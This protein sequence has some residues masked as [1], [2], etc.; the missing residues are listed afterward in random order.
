MCRYSSAQETFPSKP[1]YGHAPSFTSFVK[2]TSSYESNKDAI[3]VSED[4]Y[5][6]VEELMS[7]SDDHDSSMIV[8]P[9]S[10]PSPLPTCHS[11]SPS[12][13]LS[14][15][16]VHPAGAGGEGREGKERRRLGVGDEELTL[17]NGSSPTLKVKFSKEDISDSSPSKFKLEINEKDRDIQDLSAIKKPTSTSSIIPQSKT[18]AEAIF[19]REHEKHF[20]AVMTQIIK[21][22]GLSLSWLDIIQPL[23]VSATQTVRTDVF[24]DDVMDI[25]EYVRVKKIPCGLRSDSSLNYGAVCTKNVT[26][27]KMNTEIL[28]PS[29]LLLKCAF[30]FQ[31]RENQLSSFD[32]LHLQENKYL[33]NL[34]DKVKAFKPDIILVQKS[35]SRLALEDLYD[36]GI[37]VVVNVK[38]SVMARVSR[39]T[40]G[41]ILTSLDQLF[42]NVHLGTCGKFYVRNFTLDSGVKKT[43]MYFDHCEEKLG[44]VITLQG[45]SSRELKK[46]K[47]VTQFGLHISYNSMLES[48]FLLDEFARLNSSNEERVIIDSLG[49]Y[50]STPLTPEFSLYPSIAHPLDSLPPS[51]V[52]QRLMELGLCNDE[53]VKPPHLEVWGPDEISII[54]Q[55]G[56]EEG[57]DS[58]PVFNED[59]EEDKDVIILQETAKLMS[60]SE[61]KTCLTR[62]S[63]DVS[64]KKNENDNLTKSLTHVDSH[65]FVPQV[66][67]HTSVPQ[68]DSHT[69]V[70]RVD[71]H[72]SVPQV[73]D[74]H[75]STPQVDPHAS[76]PQVDSH[77]FIPQVDSKSEQVD[78]QT[79]FVQ[80]DSQI[81]VESPD[82]NPDLLKLQAVDRDVLIN[83]SAKEFEMV[84]KKQLLS[85]SPNVK[86]PVP[87]LQ[88]AQ[89]NEADI[90]QY[91][92][93]VIY[94]SFQFKPNVPSS[95]LLWKPQERDE[96]GDALEKG[97]TKT[98]VEETTLS[99]KCTH[100]GSGMSHQISYYKPSYKSVSE[101]PLTSSFLLLKANTNEMKAALAD[102]RSRAG[103]QTEDNS[104][105]FHSAKV[106]ADY[107]L[108]LQNLFN[109]YKQFEDELE[110]DDDEAEDIKEEGKGGKRKKRKKKH[111]WKG[112][113]K[114]TQAGTPP[115]TDALSPP[116][117]NP[118][119]VGVVPDGSD[120]TTTTPSVIYSQNSTDS[121]IREAAKESSMNSSQSS[122]SQPLPKET[123]KESSM[124]GSQSSSSQPLPKGTAKE[125]SM[126]SSLSS[127]SQPRPKDVR[128][129]SSDS[130]G[131]EFGTKFRTRNL[132][133][134]D[135]GVKNEMDDIDECRDIELSYNE[136]W[137][138]SDQVCNNETSDRG[139]S[140]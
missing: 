32:T 4:D 85:I 117:P 21:S 69:S 136:M 45:S 82:T 33:Q 27:K 44:C 9:H 43:L 25:N 101:H 47:K 100:S 133:D 53:T 122:S 70:P 86:F 74:S 1:L 17:Q 135:K 68:V 130:A 55:S 62:I 106:A 67:S 120:V 103:L 66:D 131:S 20:R 64:E 61:S 58:I 59:K 81:T 39:C 78:S 41:E 35:V 42:F 84:M 72:A 8:S 19:R 113:S 95:N 87:Y 83:L 48:S 13:Q 77:T 119:N 18:E 11:P 50:H 132:E 105:F 99:Q 31:R 10:T 90:R 12:C 22:Y 121:M 38:P 126:N 52:I 111:W 15:E 24:T 115:I 16:S 75:T 73:D 108:H 51:K 102:F 60:N 97:I 80:A 125:S 54:S 65:A 91:L 109:K 134:M 129:A 110:E 57:E 76:V 37:V 26:H 137:L 118:G 49:S 2:L 124:N 96:G 34:V 71:S 139:H 30:D 123:A 46:V 114:D 98:L 28:N 128:T 116:K 29:I 6:I 89:G 40:N 23:I 127:P 112:K 5:L 94:W 138:N 93:S 104:F 63:N 79:T 92:P 7:K 14:A 107:R 3:K 36:I 88:T 140:E 56:E